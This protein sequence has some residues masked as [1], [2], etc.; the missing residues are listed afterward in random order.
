MVLCLSIVLL[1]KPIDDSNVSAPYCT[2]LLLKGIMLTEW[3][4]SGICATAAM[5]GMANLLARITGR[6]WQVVRILATMLTTTPENGK[7]TRR[8]S[9]MLTGTIV[10]YLIGILFALCY[11]WAYSRHLLSIGLPDFL[12]YGL[13]I[14]LLAVIVWRGFIALHPH[15]PYIPVRSFLL[16]IA[17]GHLLFVLVLF[18]GVHLLSGSL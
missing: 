12:L 9:A 5:T 2:Q 10:H 17:I 15:P 6:R 16:V 4:F 18:C 11:A 7:L 13:C 1:P 14:A 3:I 8:P